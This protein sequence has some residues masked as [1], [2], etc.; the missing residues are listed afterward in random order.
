LTASSSDPKEC[1][2]FVG[3]KATRDRIAKRMN[4]VI[5]I[6]DAVGLNKPNI[7]IL[8]DE[9][10]EEVRNMK[11]RNL[12]VELLNRLLKGKIKTFSRRN[13]VQSRKF[14]ELLENAIR[15]YQNRAIE[16]TQVI[17][18]LIELAKEINAAH[19]RGENT[20]L[21]EDELAFYDALAENESAKEVL[22][23]SLLCFL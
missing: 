18:E 12:A 17:L 6:L 14:S 11:Q 16:T 7:A 23:P 4:E 8:S 21:T 3:T 19:K 22:S 13:L 9:F 5:D 20:V 2:P 10:L 1:Q 15:K